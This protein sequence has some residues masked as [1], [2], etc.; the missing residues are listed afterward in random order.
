MVVNRPIRANTNRAKSNPNRRFAPSRPIHRHHRERSG[1]RPIRAR[2]A[3]GLWLSGRGDLIQGS[4]F[5]GGNLC[6]TSRANARH[7]QRDPP[8]KSSGTSLEGPV[9]FDR[10]PSLG[11]APASI[12]ESSARPCRAACPEPP[13]VGAVFSLR[14]AISDRARSARRS[15][16]SPARVHRSRPAAIATTARTVVH[17]RPEGLGSTR[18]CHGASIVA[19]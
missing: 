17:D 5:K 18:G 11:S 4:R 15:R 19:S 16:R 2:L 14:L 12:G 7:Q 8:A 3:V 6:G 10:P 1:S 9:E 13:A